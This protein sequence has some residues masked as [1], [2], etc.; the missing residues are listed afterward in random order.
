MGERGGEERSGA[1]GRLKA[2]GGYIVE[3]DAL[4][5]PVVEVTTAVP[6]FVGYAARDHEGDQPL[7]FRPRRIGSLA[8]FEHL[9]GGPPELTGAFTLTD[10]PPR[11]LD[12]ARTLAIP[13]GPREP[14]AR[15]NGADW[16]LARTP[17][18]PRSYLYYGLKSFWENGG[19]PC[20]VVSIGSYEA[21]SAPDPDDFTRGL[22]ALLGEQEPSLLVLPDAV[23]LSGD[24]CTAVQSAAVEHCARLGSRFAILD[25]FRGFQARGARG[26]PDCIDDFR[27]IRAE[28]LAYAAA[29]YPW[30]DTTVVSESEVTYR[31]FDA[32]GLDAVR[33]ILAEELAQPADDGGTR[34]SR[35]PQLIAAIGDDAA[36]VEAIHAALLGS[37]RTFEALVERVRGELNRLPPS[38]TM[39]GVYALVDN[40]GGV[41]KAP[42]NVS[43]AGVVKPAVSITEEQQ[44]DLNAPLDGK[45]VNAIRSFVGEG[46][47]VWGA[48]TLDGNGL[49]WRYVSVRRTMIMLEQSIRVA[50]KAYVFE[51]NDGKTWSAL[52]GMIGNFLTGIWKR[53]GLAGAAPEDAYSVHVGLGETMTAQDVLDGILRVTVLVAPTRPAEFVEITLEQRM[54]KP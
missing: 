5:N 35:L 23:L 20:T 7:A 2:P 15:L 19:G 41:W 12:D 46:T 44:R 50:C 29:Y 21:A 43:L 22:D 31:V 24:A 40:M 51:A 32:A 3:K 8:E 54:Q 37:S 25:V 42:A 26:Q 48:R 6:A 18:H 38:A 4:P 11:E 10:V 14:V 27:R 52:E 53:G 47:L 49:D 17:G 36:P 30:I 33:R 39:A 45:A 34:P 28:R 1:V 9:F 13:E 16:Y